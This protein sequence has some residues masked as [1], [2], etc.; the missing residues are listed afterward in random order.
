MLT[1]TEE[2]RIRKFTSDMDAGTADAMRSLFDYSKPGCDDATYELIDAVHKAGQKVSAPTIS[3]FQ[4]YGLVLPSGDIP[5]PIKAAVRKAV[6]LRYLLMH[7]QTA[8]TLKPDLL[9]FDYR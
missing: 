4:P 5:K 7:N 3:A 1:A 8:P 2:L 9:I 6:A